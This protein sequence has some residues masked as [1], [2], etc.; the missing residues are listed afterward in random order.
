[1]KVEFLR[2]GSKTIVWRLVQSIV[3]ITHLLRHI[4]HKVQPVCMHVSVN[5]RCAHV[6]TNSLGQVDTR[7][8]LFPHFFNIS[9]YFFQGCCYGRDER[10]LFLG[11][12]GARTYGVDSQERKKRVIWQASCT[13]R[14][15]TRQGGWECCV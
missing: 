2:N 6:C 8:S 14:Y 1:M 15:T 10:A 4:G 3:E 7:L 12:K 9:I 5:E 13:L 11:G